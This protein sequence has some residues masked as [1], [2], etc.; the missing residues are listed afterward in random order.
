MNNIIKITTKSNRCTIFKR[1][2]EYSIFGSYLSA[3]VPLTCGVNVLHGFDYGFYLSDFSNSSSITSID[4]NDFD[5]SKISSM[6]F[7]FCYCSRLRDID[8]SHFNTSN[9]FDMSHMFYYSFIDN[10]NLQNFD[11][12]RVRNFS[13]MFAGCSNLNTLDLSNFTSDNLY[14]THSMFMNCFNL[15]YINLSNLTARNLHNCVSM[16][17]NCCRLEVLDLSKFNPECIRGARGMF[18]GCNS[19]RVIKCTEEFKNWCLSHKSLIALPYHTK[20]SDEFKWE[21]ID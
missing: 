11:T 19:L 15:K 2:C 16:F 3:P 1:M 9:T 8:L 6:S 13:G 4:L 5:T 7:M 18:Y 12:S 10:I 21:I 17:D 20:K 14:A